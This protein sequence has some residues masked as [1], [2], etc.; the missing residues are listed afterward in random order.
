MEAVVGDAI[1]MSIAGHTR[2][3]YAAAWERYSVWCRSLGEEPLPVTEDKALAYVAV[4][5]GEGLKAGTVK[6]HLAGLRMAQIKAGMRAPDWSTM[7]RLTQL[8]KGLARME[9]VGGGS[10]QARE[11]VKW[12]HMRAMQSAWRSKGERGTMLW[13]A[14]C[15]CFFGCLRAGEAL[16]PESGEF[17]AKA[18]LSWEDV[19]LDKAK[20]PGWIRVRIKES[21]TD[22]MRVGAYVTL[23]RTD[24]DICP[25][26]AVL[27]FM[28]C[29]SGTRTLL[30]GEGRRE[31]HQTWVRGGSPKGP[32]GEWD[33]RVGYLWA[34]LPH[35]GSYGCGCGRS[36]G[37]RSE[38]SGEIDE[39]RI[40]GLH[41]ERG[42]GPGLL[43]K[44]V[45]GVIQG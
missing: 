29:R 10:P 38:S 37:R 7:D 39:P 42:G 19:Q 2:R 26:R 8:K 13:A 15:M 41:K 18:H 5:A 12:V 6:Y 33:S 40:Q 16:A 4:L 30:L 20:S 23:H 35:W 27:E 34:Q 11:P 31:S 3:R 32:R 9:A 24:R 44:K 22:R 45:D 28:V 43:G 1:D 36:V 17:D 14:A 21:K 25:V